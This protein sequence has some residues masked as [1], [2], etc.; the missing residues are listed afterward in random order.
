MWWNKIGPQGLPGPQGPKGDTGEKGDKGDTG[1]EGS[2]GPQGIPGQQGA[3]GDKGD[4]GDVGPEGLQGEPA[5]Q[6]AGDIAFINHC[7]GEVFI[8][9]KDGTVW[10]AYGSGWHRA[11]SLDPP[12]PV[13]EIVTWDLSHLLDINGVVWGDTSFNRNTCTDPSNIN[14]IPR[15]INVNAMPFLR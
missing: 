11:P 7:S 15:W 3:K 14:G 6:G 10:Y 1:S 4:K 2:M 9:L 13:S 8:L 5:P 12:F